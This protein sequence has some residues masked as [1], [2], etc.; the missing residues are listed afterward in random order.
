[1]SESHS[2]IDRNAGRT[3]SSK[4]FKIEGNRKEDLLECS[5]MD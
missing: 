3:F 4:L 5:R 1:M 2:V